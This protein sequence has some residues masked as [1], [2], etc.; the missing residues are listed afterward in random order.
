MNVEIIEQLEYAFKG[1]DI[2]E[3]DVQLIFVILD[4]SDENMYYDV[5][6]IADKFGLKTQCYPADNVHRMGSLRERLHKRFNQKIEC[7]KTPKKTVYVDWSSKGNKTSYYAGPN[8]FGTKP[9]K[10]VTQNLKLD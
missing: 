6:D 2:M 5:K 4:D 10:E 7:R 3:Q 1:F 9:T 8:N